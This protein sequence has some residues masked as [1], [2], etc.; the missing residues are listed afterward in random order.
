MHTHMYYLVYV[1][2]EVSV[3]FASGVQTSYVVQSTMHVSIPVH[4]W[5][6]ELIRWLHQLYQVLSDDEL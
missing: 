6:K 3:C 1:A 5:I 2:I 4:G